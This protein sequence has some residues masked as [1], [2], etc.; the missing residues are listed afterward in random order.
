M[1]A[2]AHIGL[3][4]AVKPINPR[5]PVWMSIIACE[6]IDIL[7][8][9]FQRIGIESMGNVPW[10]HGLSASLLWSI[11]IGAVFYIIYRDRRIGILMGGL[12]FSHWVIDL[13][14]HPMGAVLG[15]AYSKSDLHLL[16]PQSPTVGLGLY[17]HS[18]VLAYVIEFGSLAIGLLIYGFYRKRASNPIEKKIE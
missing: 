18:M 7:C 16:G 8:V 9:I 1:A 15:E 4:F 11:F 13:I 6:A 14:T 17:N 2:L 10:S 5:I 3:G 12:V